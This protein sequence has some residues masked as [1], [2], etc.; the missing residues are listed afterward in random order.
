MNALI[1][2]GQCPCQGWHST[3]LDPRAEEDVNL[4]KESA[5]NLPLTIYRPKVQQRCTTFL[6][7][8]RVKVVP[9]GDGWCGKQGRLTK[10]MVVTLW[11]DDIR[12]NS[13]SSIQISS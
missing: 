5:L 10:Y 8:L 3:T 13:C 9:M 4:P 11:V 6:I 2:E 12:F 1:V 7:Y